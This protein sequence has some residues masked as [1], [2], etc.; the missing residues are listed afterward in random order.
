MKTLTFCFFEK[1]RDLTKNKEKIHLFLVFNTMYEIFNL[2]NTNGGTPRVKIGLIN[3][4]YQD[5]RNR[6]SLT[7]KRSVVGQCS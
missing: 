2:I 5:D 1:I 3:H 7:V 6:V 4:E